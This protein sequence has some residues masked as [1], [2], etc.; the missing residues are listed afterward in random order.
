MHIE[1]PLQHLSDHRQ[2]QIAWTWLGLMAF[3]MIVLLI[4]CV[5]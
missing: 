3:I 1:L 4:V 2:R 5:L